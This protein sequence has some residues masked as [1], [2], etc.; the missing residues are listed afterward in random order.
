AGAI[1]RRDEQN[2]GLL[3][4]PGWDPAHDWPGMIPPEKLPR[5]YNPPSGLIVTANNKIVGDDYPYFMGIEY[6]PGW[7]AARLEEMLTEK[8]RFS[9]RDM[10]EMQLDTMSKY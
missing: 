4:A 2:P 6:L 1:P 5:V 7:R 9:R 8:E 3:P 10:E